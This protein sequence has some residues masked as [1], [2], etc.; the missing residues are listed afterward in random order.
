MK[1]VFLHIFIF[2]GIFASAQEVKVTISPKK[3]KIGEQSKI[4]IS[5][6]Y[7]PGEEK[8]DIIW[9]EFG[10][11]LLGKVEI[12]EKGKIKNGKVKNSDQPNLIE[13]TQTLTV[14]SF[15]SGYYAI[16]P[17]QVIVNNDTLLSNPVLLEVHTVNVDTTRQFKKIKDIYETSLSLG[18]YFRMFGNWLYDNLYWILPLAILILALIFYLWWKKRKKPELKVPE[19]II[20]AHITALEH[21]KLLEDKKLWHNGMIKEYYIEMTDILRT[22]IENRFRIHA[23]E[24]TT[25]EIMSQLRLTDISEISKLTLVPVLKLSDLVKFA[26]EN[27]IGL[28]NE[29][30]MQRAKDFI[31]STI[32]TISK[33]K[34]EG[35]DG[36]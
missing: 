24:Q 3:I 5:Y 36:I 10:D 30:M 11:T 17:I 23:M 6:Q 22:Y 29:E 4:N 15:D 20:P 8:T 21:L 35:E 7:E 14:T 16:P 27:P 33:S 18:D 2:L 1:I 26:K 25:D 34:K 32:P 12:L 28:E 31:T 19:I 13:R 9:P